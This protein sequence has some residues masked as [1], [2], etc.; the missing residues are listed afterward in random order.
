M[1]QILITFDKPLS[2]SLTQNI[3]MVKQN[4]EKVSEADTDTGLQVGIFFLMSWNFILIS[5]SCPHRHVWYQVNEEKIF[6]LHF[7]CQKL[8]FFLIK[9]GSPIVHTCICLCRSRRKKHTDV[10]DFTS[11]ENR[12]LL[13]QM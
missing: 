8:L 3:R 11:K 4:K 10:K 5:P 13:M 6:V 2:P 9:R 1:A 12:E 7:L